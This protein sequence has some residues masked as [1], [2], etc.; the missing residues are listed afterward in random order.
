MATNADSAVLAFS[1]V[2]QRMSAGEGSLQKLMTD[3][4]LYDEFLKAVIDLQALVN[5]IRENPEAF[6]PEVRVKIF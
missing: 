3:P 5:G 6:K 4:Q 1:G 2:V